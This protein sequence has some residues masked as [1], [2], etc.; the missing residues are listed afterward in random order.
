MI[1]R[2]KIHLLSLG[3]MGGCTKFQKL[4]KKKKDIMKKV[5]AYLS[6]ICREKFYGI[7]KARFKSVGK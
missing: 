7:A 2:L 1:V 4:K 5:R 6:R 3:L